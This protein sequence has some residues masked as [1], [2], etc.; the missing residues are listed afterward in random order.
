MKASE[1]ILA[2][3]PDLIASLAAIKRAAQMARQIAIQ[4]NTGI[5]VIKSGEI[6]KVSA[7]EL[8]QQLS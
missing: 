4:S 6:C 5:V 8:K 7:D 2:K 3:N 1:L